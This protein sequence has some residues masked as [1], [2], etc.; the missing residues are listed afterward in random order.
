MIIKHADRYVIVGLIK[1]C[2][3]LHDVHEKSYSE[4]VDYELELAVINLKRFRSIIHFKIRRGY[5]W[6]TIRN[7]LKIN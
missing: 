4:D 5:F 1:Q 3:I 2:S 6:K 7:E